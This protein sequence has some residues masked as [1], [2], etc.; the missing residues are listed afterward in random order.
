M[1]NLDKT[2]FKDIFKKYP[3]I[4]A[5]YLF[6][7]MAS[8]KAYAESD[9]DLAVISDDPALAEKKLDILTDLAQAGMCNVDLVFPTDNDI[10]LQYETIKQNN[11]IY[12]VPG[13]DRGAIYSKIIRKYFDFYPYLKVQRLAYKE[14]ILNGSTGSHSKTTK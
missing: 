13:F 7:S 8:G 6:G 10:V 11:L 1:K 9:L 3:A 5:V 4:R 12:H 2:L 14:R